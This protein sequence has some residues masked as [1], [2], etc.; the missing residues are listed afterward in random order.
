[1]SAR[2]PRNL[3][4]LSF[5]V[6]IHYRGYFLLPSTVRLEVTI[7]L[8]EESKRS[9]FNRREDVKR[10]IYVNETKTTRNL[11]LAEKINYHFD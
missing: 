7:S 2:F 11:S 10:S 3:S 1:M 6:L 4:N 8:N 5:D 9:A